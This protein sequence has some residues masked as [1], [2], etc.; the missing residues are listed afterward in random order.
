MRKEG[1]YDMI[2]E[3]WLKYQRLF[4]GD[5]LKRVTV[6]TLTKLKDSRA[7]AFVKEFVKNDLRKMELGDLNW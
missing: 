5:M 4:Q 1:V 6:V 2:V 7:D 3:K